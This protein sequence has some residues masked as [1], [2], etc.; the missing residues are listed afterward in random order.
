[1]NKKDMLQNAKDHCFFIGVSDSGAELCKANSVYGIAGIHSIQKELGM[2]PNA[3]FITTPDMTITRNSSR[4][5]SGFGYGGKISWGD[6]KDRIIVLD[7]KPN[8][9][10]M[11]V[12][13]LDHF[14]DIEDVIKRLHEFEAEPIIMD[15]IQVTLDFYKSNHFID[16][17]RLKPME[18]LDLP[19]Y[20]FVIHGSASELKG[21]NKLGFGLYYDRSKLLKEKAQQID[22]PFG[23]YHILTDKD[24]EKYLER[25]QYVEDFAIRKR[26]LAAKMIFG[27]Y[28]DISN[29]THQGLL[30]QNEIVLGCHHLNNE[31]DIYPLTLRGDLPA[32]LVK[33]VPNLIP[34]S[35]DFLGFEKRANKLDLFDRLLNANII[36]HGGGYVLPDTLTVNKVIEINGKRYFE[37]DMQNDRGKKVISDVREL[38]YEYR[39]RSVVLRALEIGSIEIVAKMIPEYVMKI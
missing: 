35:I 8:A 24:A 21:D 34:E 37:V 23:K 38:A 19:P 4:W 32:Y 2:E 29:V 39:G 36:P 18:K 17:F 27:K 28:K 9:C 15:D 20:A 13:G 33:G 22:T 26:R 14:P 6:G 25:Y 11:L 30:N 1:M 5:K 31:S 10:G 12:G 16:V 3:T 7:V